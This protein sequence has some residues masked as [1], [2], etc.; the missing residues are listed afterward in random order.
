MLDTFLKT[1]KI[2]TYFKQID[3]YNKN[4]CYLSATRIRVNK[5]CCDRFSSIDFK[6]DGKYFATQNMKDKQIFN[7][8]KF[9]VE[10]QYYT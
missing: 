9:I 2:S 7:T 1:G 6:Y 8:M 3:K 10:D 4:I 5:E